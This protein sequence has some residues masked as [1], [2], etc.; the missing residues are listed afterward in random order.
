MKRYIVAHWRGQLSLARSFL[1]NGVLGYVV[2]IAL[3]VGGSQIIDSKAFNY[4]GIS[5]FAAW[6]VWSLVG[7]LRCILRL[8]REQHSIFQRMLAVLVLVVVAIV[9]YEII[10]DLGMIAR[11]AAW[12]D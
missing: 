10:S 11:L 5:V 4:A 1:V 7:I 8:F 12:Q 9:V 2:L 3:L 6:Q